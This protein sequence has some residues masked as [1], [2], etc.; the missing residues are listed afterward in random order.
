LLQGVYLWVLEQNVGAQ[1]FYQTMGGACVERALA[2]A[3]GGDLARLN[4]N[5]CRLRYVWPDP[6]VLLER[7]THPCRQQPA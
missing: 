1:A 6:N 4:G 7:H 2:P 5:P 3:P